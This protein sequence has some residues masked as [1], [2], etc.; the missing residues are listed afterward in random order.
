MM[1]RPYQERVVAKAAAALEKHGN[2]LVVSPTGS[3]KTIILSAL[4]RRVAPKKT[5]ILQH[6]DELV[7]QNMEK[8]LK[9]NPKSWPSLY[10][11]D[12]KSWGG[13][14]IFAMVQTLARHTQTI[15]SIDLLIVDEA[16]HSVASSYRKIIDAVLAGNPSCKVAGFTAT[17]ERSDKKG[18]LSIFSN[19]ADQ[20]TIR[21]LIDLGFLVPP[22]SFVVDVGTQNELSK[23][24]RLASDYDMDEVE[25]VM[26]KTVINNEVVRNWREK[27]EDRRTIVFC[28]TVAHAEAMEAAFTAEGIAAATVTGDTP[29]KE[30][31]D[32]IKRLRAGAVQVICNVAVFTEG[33]DEPMVS[34]IVLL[35]HC[36]Y[37]SP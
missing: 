4:A 22:R 31:K 11:A 21:E 15:P 5:L 12:S 27:A 17:P 36:S 37:K 34:C 6:R 2:T 20:I 19:V 35:R 26:N 25:K 29:D 3:G 33:F 8:F 30:R 28:S 18:L 16:H 13:S 24:R 14:A 32:I 23:V 9:I 7:S 10:T 1:L